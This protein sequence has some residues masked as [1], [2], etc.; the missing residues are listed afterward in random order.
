MTMSISVL[1]AALAL[2]VARADEGFELMVADSPTPI[3]RTCYKV[4]DASALEGL[5]GTFFQPSVGKFGMG[6]KDF[7]AILDA[8]GKMHK[9]EF[10]EADG[11]VCV[12]A[13][14]MD[15]GFYN[16]SRE[17]NTI[18]PAILFDE[19]TPPRKCGLLD[20]MCNMK[21][22]NDNVFVNT[23]SVGDKM[24]AVTDSMTWLELDPVTLDMR[25]IA[26]WA[27]GLEQS[28]HMAML[29]SAHP[30]P[31]PDSSG[32]VVGL[33]A[34]VGFGPGAT[35]A[36]DIFET[37]A[38]NQS[39]ARS[40]LARID[41]TALADFV[42]PD[43]L[44]T[45][46][47]WLPY[48]HAFGLT[49]D[50]A[51]LPVQPMTVDWNALLLHGAMMKD[52]FIELTEMGG[53]PIVVAPLDG[54]GGN[55][56][57]YMASRFFFT[58]VVNTFVEDA[59]DGGATV[60]DVACSGNNPFVS[61]LVNVATVQDKA[62]RDSLVTAE[63]A[64]LMHV[65]RVRL[66]PGSADGG[67]VGTTEETVLTNAA[68]STDFTKINP[69]FAGFPYCN[70]WG[71]TWNL[72][73]SG[74]YGNMGIVKKDLCS[75]AAA[76]DYAGVWHRDGWFPYEPTFVPTGDAEGGAEDEGKLVF[77]AL[78]G[79]TNSSF[80]V[81]ADAATMESLLELPLPHP[82]SFATHGEFYGGYH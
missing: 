33:E 73:L 63:D 16:A 29:G 50:A 58:H 67:V 77:L 26:P 44:S 43:G 68:R 32:G 27:E 37:D 12:S 20:P 1:V 40:L 49:A 82:I 19:T 3:A 46:D 75:G 79:T 38:T 57:A 59:A 51:V 6:D 7:T 80:L 47:N 76:D 53:T 24:F 70:F 11:S 54:D 56:T 35:Y 61:E 69:R 30:I 45:T 34:E 78:D 21:G 71:V 81:V 64:S 60:I 39:A 65:R 25:G 13:K 9:F 10:V 2:V 62:T 48:F 18:A 52:A 55:W 15:T 31:R 8:F 36:I 28:N 4:D 22:A 23:V 66:V 74:T 5:D 17:T 42:V 41:T 72:D 14:M